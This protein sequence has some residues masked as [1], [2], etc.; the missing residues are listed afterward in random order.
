MP[1]WTNRLRSFLGQNRELEARLAYLTQRRQDL[2]ALPDA[3]DPET[4]VELEE[5]LDQIREDLQAHRPERA[6]NGLNDLDEHLAALEHEAEEANEEREAHAERVAR[7]RRSLGASRSRL[8]GL[9]LGGI[10][11]D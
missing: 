11:S 10:G 3:P 7:L 2:A 1:D 9:R 4:L 6:A 5:E 8:I